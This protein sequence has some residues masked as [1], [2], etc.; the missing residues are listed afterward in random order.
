VGLWPY[1]DGIFTQSNFG[2]VTKLG[3]WSDAGPPVFKPFLIRYKD[4][5][6]VAE[7]IDT[8]RP[9]RISMSFPMP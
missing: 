5:R 3:F 1:L 2:I 8:I 6:D 7:I 4:E 9:L